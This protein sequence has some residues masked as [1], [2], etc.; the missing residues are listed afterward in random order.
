MLVVRDL[1]L[2]PPRALR[3]RR[4]RATVAAAARRCRSSGA[5]AAASRRWIS[6]GP[7][8]HP[9][10]GVHEA[11]AGDRARALLPSH[12][13]PGGAA[14]ASTPI[15][16]A[17]PAGVP[18]RADPRAARPRHRRRA[19]DRR[20]HDAAPAAGSGCAGSLM[21][22]AV[23]RRRGAAPLGPPQGLPAAAHPHLPRPRDGP[24]RRRLP[25][26]PVE[27]RDRL[28]GCSGARASC[29]ARRTSST[30]FPSSTPTSSS[31]CSPRSGASSARCVLIGALP[32][33]ACCAAS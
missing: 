26:H 17:R 12:A 3:V 15:P 23:G 13:A 29:T 32:G 2:P 25:R 10:V 1:R 4:L 28:R 18:R 24:A 33:A 16:A 11:R 6:L 27:D 19:R 5:S 30:S 22:G 20:L 7:V 14:A 31:R 9:A 8:S 21:L